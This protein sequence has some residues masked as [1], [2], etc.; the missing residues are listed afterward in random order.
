[1]PGHD[2]IVIGASAGGLAPLRALVAALPLDLPA[3]AFAV[4]HGSTS[5]RQHLP[6]VVRDNSQFSVRFARDR[7]H[8]ARGT[9]LLAPPDRHLILHENEVRLS[10]G[11]HENQWR[12]AVDVLF[13]SAAIAFSSRV[14]A[15]VLS[16]ALDDGTAGLQAVRACG[17]LT[18]V[19][20]PA[21]AEFPDMPASALRAVEGTEPLSTP[22]LSKRIVELVR[23]PAGKPGEIPERLRVEARYAEGP[24]VPLEEHAKLGPLSYNS[25]PECGG[26]MRQV[27]GTPLRYRCHTGH[28]YTG[29]VLEQ[30]TRRDIEASLWTAVRLFQQRSSLD[31]DMAQRESERGRLQGADSYAS[32]AAE[33][34]AHASVLLDLL[35][36]LP[37]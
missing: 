1:M 21:E 24:R 33:A 37:D 19:Q 32:R 3:C 8:A 4:V 36:S 7:D 22:E 15:V 27:P 14:I 30:E 23:T 11:P 29:I 31:R 9:L 12:P 5:D 35:M 2:I 20:D 25:C 17:G 16:G 10:R 13:R 28:A 26:P 18:L 34:E 6:E